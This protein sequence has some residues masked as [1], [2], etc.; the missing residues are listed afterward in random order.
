MAHDDV[1]FP[2]NIAYGAKGGPRFKTTIFQT[3]GGWEQR[4]QSWADRRGEWD[5]AQG[6]KQQDDVNELVAFFHAR[7]G[8][9]RSFLFKDWIDFKS[10]MFDDVPPPATGIKFAAGD[11]P[12]NLQDGRTA[13]Q[14]T[15]WYPDN[16]SNP[17]ATQRYIRRLYKP[18]VATLQL[19]KNGA[20]LT[21]P[22][23][24]TVSAT[25]LITFASAPGG[26]DVL[27]WEGDFYVP[28]RFDDDHMPAEI[29]YFDAVTWP[30]KIVEVRLP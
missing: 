7:L 27:T 6:L 5:V 14:L 22:A 23:D 12:E 13:F 2:E 28:V 9:A 30:C 11:V 29:E 4:N 17:T 25:G 3:A 18:V 8:R 24:Y 10:W 15:K 19:W 20:P 21:N 26:G 1:L 16:V